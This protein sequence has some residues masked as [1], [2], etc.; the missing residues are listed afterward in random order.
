MSISVVIPCFNHGRYLD[1]A[2]DSVFAQTDQDFEI[3]IVN[4]GSTDPETNRLLENYRRPRTRVVRTENRGLPGAR[5]VGIRMTDAPL[6]CALDADD[7]LEPEWFE[8]ARAVLDAEPDVA[9]VSHWLRTFGDEHWEWTPERCDLV[10]LLDMNTINGAALVRR[11]AIEA[12]DFF[13]ES[14]RDGC[15]DWDLWL[16]MVES[17]RRGVILPEFLFRYRRRPESMSRVMNRPAMQL[18]LF[19]GLIEK[20]GASYRKHLLDLLQRRETNLCDLRGEMY[21]LEREYHQW[22]DPELQRRR[23]EV[24]VLR[25]KAQKIHERLELEREVEEARGVQAE[26]DVLRALPDRIK[27]IQADL[28]GH[29]QVLA[30]TQADLDGHRKALANAEAE[31][32]EKQAVESANQEHLQAISERLAMVEQE[33]TKLAQRDANQA[34]ESEEL[35]RQLETA[36]QEI[37]ERQAELERQQEDLAGHKQALDAARNENTALQTSWSWRVAAPLRAVFRLLGGGGGG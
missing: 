14:M 32:A 28:D 16:R 37:I 36:R 8:K 24:E 10:S 1:E 2:V 11:E 22:W 34:T 27:Q 4:D 18:D 7:I 23:A 13:D 17:G 21:D 29:R 3:L 5:N 6:I 19:R 26:L 9:F 12:I 25:K 31:I 33:R 30:Q 15:E 20:H 35:R